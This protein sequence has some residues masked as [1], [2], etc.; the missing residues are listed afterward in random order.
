VHETALFEANHVCSGIQL[1]R[2][3]HL[4][5]L[6]QCSK[7]DSRSINIYSKVRPCM[8]V[9]G[10]AADDLLRQC[11]HA[12]PLTGTFTLLLLPIGAWQLNREGAAVKDS[13]THKRSAKGAGQQQWQQN[14][15][16]VTHRGHQLA[17]RLTK[18]DASNQQAH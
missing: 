12:S 8:A 14:T 13:H 5:V 10:I 11:A 9:L 17:R 16:T 15:L 4:T 6:T 1:L 3:L 2:L 7:S 18:P